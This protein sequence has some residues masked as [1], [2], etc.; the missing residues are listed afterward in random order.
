MAGP[1]YYKYGTGTALLQGG[2][3]IIEAID[4]GKSKA[5]KREADRLA[6]KGLQRQDAQSEL[7]A[8]TAMQDRA[9]NSYYTAGFTDDSDLS[10]ID[11]ESF[12]TVLTQGDPTRAHNTLIQGFNLNPE[13]INSPNGTKITSMEMRGA[14]SKDGEIIFSGNLD[15]PET[16]KRMQLAQERGETAHTAFA[17][18]GK[19]ADGSDA[20]ITED[21][22]G[23]SGS[24]VQ[25]MGMD[26]LYK[27]VNKNYQTNIWTGSTA[28][29][30]TYSF[31]QKRAADTSNEAVAAV[32]RAKLQAIQ[33]DRTNAG[34]VNEVINHFLD[35]GQP[36]AAR[37]VSSAAVKYHDEPEKFNELLNQVYTDVMGDI[38]VEDGIKVDAASEVAGLVDRYTQ[39]K[40]Q[41][42]EK[43]ATL[44]LLPSAESDLAEA[45]A[46]AYPDEDESIGYIGSL[47]A[48][49][50]RASSLVEAAIEGVGRLSTLERAPGG[51]LTSKGMTTAAA[52]KYNSLIKR[53]ARLEARI[54]DTKT[55]DDSPVA[56]IRIAK[57]KNAASA[58]KGL[59]KID[60]QLE[61][62]KIEIVDNYAKDNPDAPGVEE[63]IT[64]KVASDNART[65]LTMSA[66]VQED[67]SAT[68]T[69]QKIQSGE[70]VFTDKEMGAHRQFL[71]AAGVSS[72]E[73]V[74]ALSPRQRILTSATLMYL[75]R[76]NSTRAN[77]IARELDELA[78]YGSTTGDFARAKAVAEADTARISATSKASESAESDRNQ[79]DTNV[80]GGNMPSLIAKAQSAL[81]AVA[82]RV[83]DK[84]DEGFDDGEL[85]GSVGPALKRLARKIET[86]RS[87]EQSDAAKRAEV[88]LFS[89]S[90]RMLSLGDVEGTPVKLFSAE[91]LDLGT[92]EEQEA[93]V[94]DPLGQ[95]IQ[96]SR[97][98]N[99]SVK[100]FVVMSGSDSSEPI[101]RRVPIDVVARELGVSR[102]QINRVADNFEVAKSQ[103]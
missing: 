81:D 18:I 69:L 100:E 32:S 57:T 85:R 86:T 95:F 97:S 73:D 51:E 23:D 49:N 65:I 56:A 101:S 53:K 67:S 83:A 4:E 45:L 90:I 15:D 40:S 44:G 89:Q 41:S 7:E 24:V 80:F 14:V 34:K 72:L 91:R 102:N 42:K 2:L 27:N 26:E 50:Q 36:D 19:N 8:R 79:A 64:A 3:G 33:A 96:V 103:L 93:A 88:Q 77:E 20:V 99:G 47:D 92:D 29:Q 59:A 21:A 37:A 94:V 5:I 62:L 38:E 52:K 13:M 63:Y 39:A 11:R 16:K 30:A 84:G 76:D 58:Q 71:E 54:A 12:A 74:A 60:K 68:D 82:L 10:K 31:Y 66:S 46:T 70:I 43:D 22:G 55:A 1:N 48:V 17:L 61:D 28:E 35:K 98:P 87:G 78:L 6:L 25:L 75:N 9:Q